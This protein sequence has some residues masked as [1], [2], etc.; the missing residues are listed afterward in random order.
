M[1]VDLNGADIPPSATEPS[2]ER[3][4]A[5]MAELL[6]VGPEVA[7][8]AF[9]KMTAEQ[10]D[11][12]LL[13]L[14]AFWQFQREIWIGLDTWNTRQKHYVLPDAPPEPEIH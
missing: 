6:V 7:G 8:D 11:Q 5:F 10:R 4:A 2:F 12:L 14:H 13:D 9:Q 1:L 3:G